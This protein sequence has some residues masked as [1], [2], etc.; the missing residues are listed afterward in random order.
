MSGANDRRDQVA[1]ARTI[2]G[3]GQI[4]RKGLQRLAVAGGRAQRRVD[5]LH[6]LL[7]LAE[8]ENAG[9]LGVPRRALRRQVLVVE[10]LDIVAVER[11]VLG[12][13]LLDGFVHGGLVPAHIGVPNL[14]GA[15]IGR[16]PIGLHQLEGALSDKEGA[17]DIHVV[18]LH[19]LLTSAAATWMKSV[20]R[21]PKDI[22]NNR[23]RG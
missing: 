14:I 12:R 1:D 11:A 7:D 2:E 8:H 22:R 9:F 21:C 3:A 17:I 19:G 18:R 23:R 6:D 16:R 20:V 13:D 15:R 4:V 5:H 10:L